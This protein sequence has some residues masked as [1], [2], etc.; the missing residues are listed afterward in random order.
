M[1]YGGISCLPV[2]SNIEKRGTNGERERDKR[3]EKA[4]KHI[5]YRGESV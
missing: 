1:E 3:K 2:G 4:P 5:G